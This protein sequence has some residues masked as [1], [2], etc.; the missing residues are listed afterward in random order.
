M[1]FPRH[2]HNGF[3]GNGCGILHHAFADSL[4]IHKQDDLH[5]NRSSQNPSIHFHHGSLQR[6]R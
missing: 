4:V 6:L 2:I 3:S 1:D 5:I